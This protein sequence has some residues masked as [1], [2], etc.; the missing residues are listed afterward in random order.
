MARRLLFALLVLLLSAPA[1]RAVALPLKTATEWAR[2]LYTAEAERIAQG[3]TLVDDEFQAL[4]T[5]DIVELWRAA[6]ANPHPNPPVGPTLNPLFGWNVPPGSDVKLLSVAVLLGTPMAPV[7]VIDLMVRRAPRR[8]ILHLIEQPSDWRI[9]GIFYDEGED[10][11]SFEK[12]LAG[13]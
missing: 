12:R 6:K 11:I 1:T 13:R 7:L 4:F 9:S 5:P 2:D 3:S 8:V 10:F